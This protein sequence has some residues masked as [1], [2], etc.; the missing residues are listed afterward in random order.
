MLAQ[1]LVQHFRSV[2]R[3]TPLKIYENFLLQQCFHKAPRPLTT[4]RYSPTPHA[5]C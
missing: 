1:L 2:V 3:F 4:G 5:D